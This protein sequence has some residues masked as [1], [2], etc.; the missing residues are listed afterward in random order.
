M[1]IGTV[2]FQ[3]AMYKQ[4]DIVLVPF[5]FTNQAGIKHRPALVISGSLVNK[6]ANI[7]LVQITSKNKV[8][9]FSIPINNSTDLT[10]LLKYLSE[11]R[12]NKL[13]VVDQSLIVTKISAVKSNIISRV[14]AII[15]ALFLP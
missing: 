5:P 2:L 15:T 7:I 4:G 1:N 8:D 14:V 9:G 11:I 3:D 10:T 13:L 12:C 6:T